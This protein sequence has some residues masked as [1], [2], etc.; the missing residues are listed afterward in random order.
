MIWSINCQV[1]M[2]NWNMAS[3]LWNDKWSSF[4]FCAVCSD[5]RDSMAHQND[6]IFF[7]MALSCPSLLK[8]E[9]NC[10]TYER[11]KFLTVVLP[12]H[13]CL[14]INLVAKCLVINL[15]ILLFQD[16]ALYILQKIIKY[17]K[18]V[19]TWNYLLCFSESPWKFTQICS[20]TL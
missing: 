6:F 20:F 2:P 11:A 15:V 19:Y 14:Y 3:S 8:I 4:T 17:K 16:Q 9:Q 12:R 5:S 1:L 10:L 13:P 7:E 18:N